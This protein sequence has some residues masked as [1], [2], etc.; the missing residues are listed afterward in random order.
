LIRFEHDP[1]GDDLAFH[2]RDAALRPV[3]IV[4]ARE[5]G[6]DVR[7]RVRAESGSLTDAEGLSATMTRRS[8]LVGL[9]QSG[10]YHAG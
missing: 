2:P 6:G 7:R 9:R 3:D 1:R 10:T 4:D 8:S 5:N